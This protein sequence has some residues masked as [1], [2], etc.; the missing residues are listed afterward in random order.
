[1]F[2]SVFMGSGMC[3]FIKK[4]EEKKER[5]RETCC[6]QCTC[7]RTPACLSFLLKLLFYIFL[8]SFSQL[9]TVFTWNLR[10]HRLKTNFIE[11]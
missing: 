1:M 9:V 8:T 6:F 2:V 11:P 5:E 3:F 7:V 4:K 10:H